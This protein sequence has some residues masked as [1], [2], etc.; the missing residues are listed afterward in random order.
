MRRKAHATADDMSDSL[1]T[2]LDGL[3]ESASELLES[4]KEQRGEAIDGLRSRATRNIESARR[5]LADMAPQLQ[6]G[7]IEVAK[8]TRGFALRNPWSTVAI[9]TLVA[10]SVGAILYATLSDE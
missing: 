3:I 9:G 2:E 7:A 4:L 10:A 1:A 8:A 5:R 6:E